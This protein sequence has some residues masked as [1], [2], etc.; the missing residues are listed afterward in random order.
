[1]KIKKILTAL[2]LLF[3]CFLLVGCNNT[4]ST[5]DEYKIS[6]NSDGADTY[7]SV[8]VKKDETYSN[9]PTPSKSGYTFLGWYYND[10]LVTNETKIVVNQDHTLIAKWKVVEEI[11]EKMEF[12]VSFDADNNDKIDSITIKN[13]DKFENLPVVTKDGYTFLGWYKGNQLI[14]NGMTVNLI[15]DVTLLARWKINQTISASNYVSPYIAFNGNQISFDGEGINISGNI[16]NITLEGTYN[17]YG[18]LSNG[19]ILINSSKQNVTLVLNGVNLSCLDN[20]VINVVKAASVTI[21]L[22]SGTENY[23]TDGTT[24]NLSTGV[25]EPNAAI[26]SKADLVINGTGSLKVNALYANGI[27]SKDTLTIESGIIDI[28]SKNNGLKGKDFVIIKGGALTINSQND[29]I[30]STNTDEGLGYILIEGGYITI[31]SLDNAIQAETDLTI[32]SGEITILSANNGLKAKNKL[33]INGGVIDV[34]CLGDGIKAANDDDTIGSIYINGGNIKIDSQDDGIQGT[35]LFEIN[36]GILNINALSDGVKVEDATSLKGIIRIN[37]GNIKIKANDDGMQAAETIENNGGTLNVTASSDGIKA[38]NSLETLG[39]V[40]I[41]GGTITIEAGTD[42]VQAHLNATLSGGNVNILT[43][44]NIHY[45]ST[46]S[47]KG[48]KASTLI[49][50]GGHL[51]IVSTNHCIHSSGTIDVRNGTINMS[52]TY[53]KGMSGHGNVTIDGGTIIVNKST[54]GIESKAIMT[55]NDGVIHIYATDD[56]INTGGTGG[57][58]G[59]GG[60][61]PRPGRPG[62]PGNP[63]G[64]GTMTSGHELYINGGYLYIDSNGDGLD[65]NSNLFINGGTIIVNGPTNNGNGALDSDG[66]ITISGGLLIAMGSSG[67]AEAPVNTSTQA[68]IKLATS[69]ISSG[70]IISIQDGSGNVLATFSPSKNISSIVFSSNELVKGSTY[71]I[72][73][74]GTYSGGNETD[75][76]FKNGT[77][78]ASGSPTNITL[79]SMTT[80]VSIRY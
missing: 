22:A 54:E 66:T 1:M 61:N 45:D 2:I 17:I 75:G 10:T 46:I 51:N 18:T 78:T 31:T 24:Y 71:K 11:V 26:F 27:Q 64:P 34:N 6:L 56:G 60:F 77:F 14:E 80:Q 70:T 39:S 35:I 79:S 15:D 21:T 72:Y 65:S 48:L 3:E 29:A 53:G 32:S 50:N 55:I 62:N 49:I 4:T 7:N 69:T 8:T 52:S 13:G 42:G 23:I 30:E 5:T 76:L 57:M 58:G 16:V 43:T 33:I 36:G 20:A 68:S 44:G 73:V 47:S 40:A 25:D 63:G 28:T 19:Q 59:I 37:N 74:G 9:L 38:E 41:S 12:T 67:M